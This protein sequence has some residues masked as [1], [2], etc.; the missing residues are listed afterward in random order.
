MLVQTVVVLLRKSAEWPELNGV[1]AGISRPGRR[2]WFSLPRRS[3][4][5]DS[6]R[7][8][9]QW[10]VGHLAAGTAWVRWRKAELPGVI[11]RMEERIRKEA[12][13]DEAGTLWTAADVLMGLKYP[14]DLMAQLMQGIMA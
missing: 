13:P 5:G 10:R 6:V 12:T 1:P 2:T 4:L 11:R 9:P 14:R 3:G 8:L 7:D